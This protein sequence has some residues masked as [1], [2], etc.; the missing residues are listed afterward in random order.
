MPNI[1]A[2]DGLWRFNAGFLSARIGEWIYAVSLNWL[3]LQE[4]SS[5][6]LLAVI[7]ACRLAPALALSLPAGYLADHYDS[8]KLSF[9]KN[10]ANAAVMIAVGVALKLH[11]PILAVCGLVLLQAFITALE[12]PIR[13]TYM[14]GLFEGERLKA[15][16]AHN[17]SLM[18]LGRIIGPVIAG[19]LLARVGGMA[20]F[21]AAALF[22]ALFSLVM[23]SLVLANPARVSAYSKKV[24]ASFSLW[25][26]L[27]GNREI[28]NIMLL[29]APMMFFGFPYTAMLSVLTETMLHMGPEQ[30]GELTAVSAAG[31]LAASSIL[32]LRPDLANWAATLRYA[33]LFAFS[34]VGLAFV[35]GFYSAALLLFLVGYLGQAYRSCSRMHLHEVLPKEGAGRILGLSLM[36]RGMIPVG[37]LMLGAITEFS[38][39]RVSYGVMGVG[40]LLTVLMFYRTRNQDSGK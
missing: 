4:S 13:N 8:R 1:S 14:N 6:W 19:V 40:C 12:A 9:L 17:A 3:V 32:G 29:A 26:T 37:G 23:G 11:L 38:S 34:L 39:A 7:N 36:D 35:Q 28:R 22:T 31:A 25:A 2:K 15:A 33:L 10:L 21:T 5:P 24:K 18:N 27:R 30:L 16:I 20:T